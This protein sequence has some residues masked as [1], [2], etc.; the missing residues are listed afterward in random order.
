MTTDPHPLFIGLLGALPQPGAE[1][2]LQKRLKW[3]Q[4]AASILDA[5]YQ[6]PLNADEREVIHVSVAI[7]AQPG[8]EG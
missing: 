7:A 5:L 1:W 8:R 4:A 3:L 6:I 2:A